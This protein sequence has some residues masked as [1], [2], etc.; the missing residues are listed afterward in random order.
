[1][2]HRRCGTSPLRSLVG[3][4]DAEWGKPAAQPSRATGLLLGFTLSSFCVFSTVD[5]LETRS[6]AAQKLQRSECE[7]LDEDFRLKLAGPDRSS[8]TICL[9][10]VGE[11]LEPVRISSSWFLAGGARRKCCPER[12]LTAKK[13]RKKVLGCEPVK[14][15]SELFACPR[16]SAPRLRR[17]QDHSSAALTSPGESR[18]LL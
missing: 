5:L 17:T 1:M 12:V 3:A 18:Q 7:N 4:V 2:A 14:F 8:S 10:A 11:M 6:V 16:P 13:V 9:R 15:Q